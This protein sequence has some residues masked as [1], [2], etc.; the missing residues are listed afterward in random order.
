MERFMGLLGSR[1]GHGGCTILNVLGFFATTT[2]TNF[3]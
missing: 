3:G 2:L 1:S